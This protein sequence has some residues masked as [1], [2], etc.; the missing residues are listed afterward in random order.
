MEEHVARAAGEAIRQQPDG[1]GPDDR[2]VSAAQL[3]AVGPGGTRIVSVTPRWGSHASSQAPPGPTAPS[4]AVSPQQTAP[5]RQ[6]PAGRPRKPAPTARQPRR[7]RGY[8][9]FSR[10]IYGTV[11]AT[12]TAL[13]TI[14]AF[15]ALFTGAVLAGL[16][17]LLVAAL[18]GRYAYRI[19]TWRA[20]VLWFVI[21][22]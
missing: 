12:Y 5:A 20:R 17:G 6:A 2:V 14:G 10:A 15:A 4:P 1:P 3:T 21:F 11:W 16:L 13:F 7:G 18:A 8:G 22:F 19:W 9:R